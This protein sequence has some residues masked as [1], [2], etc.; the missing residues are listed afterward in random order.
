MLESKYAEY[1]FPPSSG[2][3]DGTGWRLFLF[4]LLSNAIYSSKLKWARRSGA[5]AG[6]LMMNLP[7]NGHTVYLTEKQS[8]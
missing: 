2:P 6:G 8:I 4:P 7:L 5:V 3:T 1:P